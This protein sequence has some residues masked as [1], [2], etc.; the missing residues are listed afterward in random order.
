MTKFE[1]R[2]VVPVRPA[3]PWVGG[4]KQISRRLAL[5]IDGRPHDTYVEVFAGMG[6]VFLKRRRA[7]KTEIINDLNRD[8]A[9]FFRVL[10]NHYQALMDMLRWQLTSRVE[11]ERLNGM[12]PERLTDLQRAARFLYIQRTAFGGRVTG[13]TFGTAD[14]GGR[15]DVTKL[16]EILSDI[17]ERLAGVV[18]ECQPWQKLID[19][20][21][22]PGALFYLDPPYLGTEHVYGPGMFDRSDFEAISIR[23]RALQGSFIMSLND[24]PEVR[25]IFDGFTMEAVDVRYTLAGHG[26]AKVAG[27]MI[28]TGGPDG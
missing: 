12:D 19:R 25:A 21:D 4:K 11:F 26:K 24:V 13:R 20:W 5:M 14:G 27:E 16:G 18:I 22:R 1:M 9:T 28:I 7:P 8:V 3:A 17:H 15:F 23:L 6:G 10:Q 2:D